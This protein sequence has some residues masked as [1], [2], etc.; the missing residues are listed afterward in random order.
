MGGSTT[1]SIKKKSCKCKVLRTAAERRHS[2]SRLLDHNHFTEEEEQTLILSQ[3]SDW[4]NVCC[5]GDS[6]SLGLILPAALS[7][8]L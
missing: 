7:C 4:I 8:V 6:P 5:E 2:E 3:H 1:I